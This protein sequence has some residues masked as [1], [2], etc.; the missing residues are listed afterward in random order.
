MKSENVC[1][2]LQLKL[3][4]DPPG[5]VHVKYLTEPVCHVRDTLGT[6][7]CNECLHTGRVL[8][9]LIYRQKGEL[10]IKRYVIGTRLAET[11]KN[12]YASECDH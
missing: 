10:A 9:K 2:E 8:L 7:F 11:I 3:L 5:W 6:C 12:R 4:L 1:T